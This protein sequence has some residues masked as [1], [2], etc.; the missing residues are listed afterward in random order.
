MSRWSLFW[1]RPAVPLPTFAK[2]RF[3][4]TGPALSTGL[5]AANDAWLPAASRIPAALVAR[6]TVKVPVGRV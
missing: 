3:V 2:T 5:A 4:I 1:S 6:V